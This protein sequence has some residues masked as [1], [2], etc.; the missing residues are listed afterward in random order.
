MTHFPPKPTIPNYYSLSF[1]V[2]VVVLV[3]VL[4]VPVV[5]FLVINSDNDITNI[6][7]ELK[8]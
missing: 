3:V 6:N 1:R 7:L 4:I 2:V 5:S 8:E